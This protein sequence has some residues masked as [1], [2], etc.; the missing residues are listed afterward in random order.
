MGVYIRPYDSHVIAFNAGYDMGVEIR[1]GKNV[2]VSDV[3]H[4][5]KRLNE[6][7][8]AHGP[9]KALMQLATELESAEQ[10]LD[11]VGQQNRETNLEEV[12]V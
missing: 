6:T 12:D 4:M 1:E 5:I 3:Q 7:Q 11:L 9:N 8:L 10:E 2:K